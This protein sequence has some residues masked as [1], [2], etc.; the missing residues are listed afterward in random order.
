MARKKSPKKHVSVQ[1]KE[2]ALQVLVLAGALFIASILFGN[3]PMLKAAA[4]GFRMPIGVARSWARLC[5]SSGT[6]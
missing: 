2:K 5:G 4:Q 6:F 1:I 3:N